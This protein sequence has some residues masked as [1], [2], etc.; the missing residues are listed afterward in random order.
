MGNNGRHRRIKENTFLLVKETGCWEQ[1]E[2]FGMAVEKMAL[3]CKSKKGEF[4]TWIQNQK[5]KSKTK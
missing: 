4:K 1:E 3:F 5:K 2:C